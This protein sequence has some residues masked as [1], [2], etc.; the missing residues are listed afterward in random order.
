MADK[1]FKS[2]EVAPGI[3][4]LQ[5]PHGQGALGSMTLI[6]GE[7]TCA[8]VDSG[9][10]T[11]ASNQL[12]PY[13]KQIEVDERRIVTIVNTHYHGDHMGSNAQ[14]K[15]ITGASVMAHR[16]EVPF[17]ENPVLQTQDGIRKYGSYHPAHTLTAQ[18]L[19]GRGPTPVK[20]DRVLEDGDDV[21][22]A[23][24]TFKVFFTPGH[25]PGSASFYEESTGTLF[26]GDAISGEGRP[27]AL[28]RY[29]DVDQYES[30]LYRLSQLDVNLLIHGHDFLPYE[31]PV[32]KGD[33]A[34]AFIRRSREVTGLYDA[35]LVELLEKARK[36]LTLREIC[37]GMLR[38]NGRK[39]GPSV[40]MVVA[41]IFTHV[42]R[43]E[44][45]G[46]IAKLKPGPQGHPEEATWTLPGRG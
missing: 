40:F 46:A 4:H 13:L 16:V 43:L 21:Q 19:R 5:F 12:L 14:M 36:P 34:R 30:S 39:P 10:Q 41:P 38:A 42:E 3:H 25:T 28:A 37:E 8:L 7:Q 35:Q 2:T 20:V 33:Q 22:L 6:T 24:R 9:V 18:E 23:G 26:S 11:T 44:R 31:E 32:L 17:M 27:D 1:G 29:E 15:G 45:N